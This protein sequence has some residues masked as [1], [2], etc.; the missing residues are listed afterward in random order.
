MGFHTHSLAECGA[1][2]QGLI[3]TS[4]RMVFSVPAD[5]VS[6]LSSVRIPLSHDHDYIDTLGNS[7]IRRGKVNAAGEEKR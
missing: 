5:K 2:C 7:E 3:F 1:A 6:S 4:E